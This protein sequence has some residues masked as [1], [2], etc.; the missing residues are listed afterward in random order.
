MAYDG[1]GADGGLVTAAKFEPRCCV[2]ARVLSY[3]IC[4]RFRR[5][6]LAHVMVLFN[7]VLPS[8]KVLS[9]QR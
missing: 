6:C 8:T 7:Q 3:E 5:I 2:G 4:I 1:H 9:D